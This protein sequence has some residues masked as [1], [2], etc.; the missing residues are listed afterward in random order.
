MLE[1]FDVF[2]WLLFTIGCTS[3]VVPDSD[4]VWGGSSLPACPT[5]PGGVGPQ[6]ACRE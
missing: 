5:P 2:F 3:G 6:P 1:A 4:M